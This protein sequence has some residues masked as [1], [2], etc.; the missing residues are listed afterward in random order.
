MGVFLAIYDGEVTDGDCILSIADNVSG[1]GWLR[2][3]NFPPAGEQAAH[4][5]LARELAATSLDTGL[6]L[7]SQW[8]CG[9]DNVVADCLSRD[10]F[11][12]D[13][14]LT[15]FICFSFADSGQIPS[16]FKVSPCPPQIASLAYYWVQHGTLATESRPEPMP[17][18]IGTGITGQSSS[19]QSTWP[20][21]SI[22]TPSLRPKNTV[23]LEPLPNQSAS[24]TIAS[25]PSKIEPIQSLESWLQAHVVPPSIVWRR[26]SPPP[27]DPTRPKDP[28]ES[29]HTFFSVNSKDTPTTTQESNTNRR[30]LST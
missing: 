22:W 19:L 23:C 27:T 25:P 7:F 6:S 16:G 9:H 4:F 30:F 29:L 8:I 18:Q 24:A 17:R 26:P 13:A 21:T 1:A 2:K 5:G 28:T 10:D 11:R 12:S 3:S 15:D 20:M 14:E